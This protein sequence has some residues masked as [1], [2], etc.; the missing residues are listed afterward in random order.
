[1]CARG[2]SRTR[3]TLRSMDFESIASAIPPPGLV[4]G[5]L[6][7]NLKRINLNYCFGRFETWTNISRPIYFPARP[8]MMTSNANNKTSSSFT[9]CVTKKCG[10]LTVGTMLAN[11]KTAAIKEARRVKKPMVIRMPVMR[12]IQAKANEGMPA[13]GDGW[14]SQ[15]YNPGNE[16]TPSSSANAGLN[17]K[18]QPR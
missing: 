16:R 12:K 7:E 9:N 15:L 3:M 17:S 8:K 10:K 11:T 14:L 2:E 5:I 13:K 18:L 6:V 1:M 4:F